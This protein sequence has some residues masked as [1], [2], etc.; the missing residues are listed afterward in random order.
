MNNCFK[1]NNKYNVLFALMRLNPHLPNIHG[2]PNPFYYLIH[3]KHIADQL[4]LIIIL[5]IIVILIIILINKFNIVI[6]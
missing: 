1:E 5:I 3:N 2:Y 4:L 6:N